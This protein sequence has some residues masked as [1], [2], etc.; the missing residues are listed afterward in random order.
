MNIVNMALL[1]G[2][3]LTAALA[4]PLQS[5]HAATAE[6]LNADG[7]AALQRLYAQWSEGGPG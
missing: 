2:L 7:R 1:I 4:A 6:E 5:A 3:A